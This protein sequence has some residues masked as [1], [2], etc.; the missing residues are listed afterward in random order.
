MVTFYV[1]AV[2]DWTTKLLSAALK[3]EAS[4]MRADGPSTFDLLVDGPYGKLSVDLVTPTVYSHIVLFSSGIGMTPMRS[5]VNWLHHECYYKSRGVI[6]HVRFI[7]SV[8]NMEMISSLLARDEPRR[9]SC[10]QVDEVASYFPHILTHPK[11]M[12]S[13]TD[14]FVS[15]VYLFRDILDKEAQE[16]PELANC[17]HS[18]SRPDIIAILRETA[19]EAKNCGKDR[20]AIFVCGPLSLVDEVHY[21][22]TRLSRELKVHYDVHVEIFEL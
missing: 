5:I 21:A 4:A 18:G 12:N 13:P 15:E 11:N 19:E 17:L 16:M 2:G 14:A 3:R 1:E 20:I 7:W 9:D 8:T 6:P 10:L 22:S